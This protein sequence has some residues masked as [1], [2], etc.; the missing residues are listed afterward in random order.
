MGA[1]L[2]SLKDD[3]QLDLDDRDLQPGG[4]VGK[5]GV[6]GRLDLE[7]VAELIQSAPDESVIVLVGA[8]ASV[9]AGIPDFRTPGTGL[10]DNLQ[11]YDLPYPEAVFDINFFARNPAPFYRLCRE[12]WPGTYEPTPAHRF[13]KALHDH[14]KLR[15]CFTQ[16]IDSLEAAAGLPRDKVVAAHGNFDA[17]HVVGTGAPVDIEDV[18]RAVFE[19][20]ASLRALREREGG[21]VKPAITFFGEDLPPRF[22][23]C[24][25]TDF[26]DCSLL[27]IFGTSLQVHP[28]A[29]LVHRPAEGTPRMLINRERVGED[30]GLDFDSEDSS[31]GVFLGD[32]DDGARR[33]ADLCGWD[34]DGSTVG[35]P[36]ASEVDDVSRQLNKLSV[37]SDEGVDGKM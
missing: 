24:A 31:D 23:E 26:D 4:P 34:L 11:E 7:R 21:L 14:K 9:S 30:L 35:A 32:C 16:N 19:G 25:R 12:M 29:G 1:T 3:V 33:L 20:E 15:R 6:T 13:F 17:A 5:A 22:Y 37:G 2:A 8:G 27:L 18:K 10:Y 36:S 28:F